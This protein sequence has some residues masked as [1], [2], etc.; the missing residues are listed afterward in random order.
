MWQYGFNRTERQLEYGLPDVDP[1]CRDALYRPEAGLFT[2]PSA[3]A[4][5]F[6]HVSA[7]F[8]MERTFQ[9]FKST[10]RKH[11]T[12]QSTLQVP[13]QPYPLR[14]RGANIG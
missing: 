2:F 13:Q 11:E 10:T 14:G 7:R 12:R 1:A 3:M 4:G 5:I 6:G 9:R 8:A